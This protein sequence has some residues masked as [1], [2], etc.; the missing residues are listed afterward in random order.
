MTI[1][2]DLDERLMALEI[3]A[4]Y[5]EDLLER[6]DLIIIRQQDQIDRLQREVQRLR[7]PIGDQDN[8][9]QRNPRDEL[10]PHY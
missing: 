8:A 2:H 4:S 10:P 3:K 6:L 1:D 9:G 7:Q 5:A